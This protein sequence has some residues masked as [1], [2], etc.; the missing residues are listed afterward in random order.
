MKTFQFLRK[1]P[2]EPTSSGKFSSKLSGKFAGESGDFPL[3]AIGA[4]KSQSAGNE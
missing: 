2:E 3:K 1:S 4:Q